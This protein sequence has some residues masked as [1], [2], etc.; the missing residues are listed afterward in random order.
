MDEP[1]ILTLPYKGKNL[2]LD[3]QLE[4]TGYTHR[5]RVIVYETEVFF[6]K[7]D[8]GE[9]RAFVSTIDD[10]PIPHLDRDLLQAIADKIIAILA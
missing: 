10:K 5:F 8:E 9:Y 3:A 1:F 7:D 4:M 2:E 6:E